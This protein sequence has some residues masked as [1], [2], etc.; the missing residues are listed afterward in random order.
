MWCQSGIGHCG[1]Q[2]EETTPE[3]RLVH[4]EASPTRAS[5]SPPG[6][7]FTIDR[8]G[9]QQVVKTALKIVPAQ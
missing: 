5:K 1:M 7:S 9:Q 2:Q 4:E 3:M 6:M 8:D